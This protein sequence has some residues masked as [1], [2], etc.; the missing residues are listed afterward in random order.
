MEVTNLA[1]Q[2][3]V[4]VT[5]CGNLR[6]LFPSPNTHSRAGPRRSL[7][8]ESASQQVGVLPLTLS[9]AED[10]LHWETALG[11]RRVALA[12]CDSISACC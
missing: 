6:S 4:R 11:E 3:L 9:A 10:S 1:N 2:S 8:P 7:P 5:V 12:K